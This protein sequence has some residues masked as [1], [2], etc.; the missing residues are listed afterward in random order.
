MQTFDFNVNPQNSNKKSRHPFVTFLLAKIPKK[1]KSAV[2]KIGGYLKQLPLKLIGVTS[3]VIL[4][5]LWSSVHFF[6]ANPSRIVKEFSENLEVYQG[7]SHDL[8]TIHETSSSLSQDELSAF[9]TQMDNFS[10]SLKETRTSLPVK[11]FAQYAFFRAPQDLKAEITRLYGQNKL[12]SEVL[13]VS[14]AATRETAKLSQELLNKGT[15][16]IY[17]N[18]DSYIDF[19]ERSTKTLDTLDESE[20]VTLEIPRRIFSYIYLAAKDY[21]ATGNKENFELRYSNLA[22]ELAEEVGLSWDSSSQEQN[23]IINSHIQTFET[24][25]NKVEN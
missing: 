19:L 4:L 2:K 5:L 13:F 7:L 1:L 17:T 15:D 10:N 22:S 24:I 23:S 14:A 12:Q 6:F 21:Q 25:L 18:T 9:Q 3:L 20:K 11:F 8:A 16:A